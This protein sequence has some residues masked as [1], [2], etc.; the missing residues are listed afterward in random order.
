MALLGGEGLARV[1]ATCHANTARLV[2]QLSA[3]DGVDTLFDAPV[4][5]E[6]VLQLAAPAADILRSLAADD[7][8]G[9]FD[10]SADYPELGNAMLVC[11]TEMRSEAD[12][13]EYVARLTRVMAN[14]T[15]AERSAEA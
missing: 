5:H 2:G 15:R 3:I 4:F 8:L 6:S 12:I 14:H 9:G 10:L 7:L 11:A 13:A 1:A